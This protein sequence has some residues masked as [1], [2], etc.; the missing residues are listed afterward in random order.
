MG[1][2]AGL[3]FETK[4]FAKYD[5]AR[6]LEDALRK[7]GYQVA[8]IAL[9]TNTDPYQPI[10]RELKLTSSILAVL[11]DC[12]HPVTIVTKSAGILRDLDRLSRMARRGLVSVGLSVTTLDAALSRLMEPALFLAST[13]GSIPSATWLTPGFRCGSWLSPMIPGLNDCELEAIL[14]AAR[15]AGARAASMIPLRLPL[16]VKDVF[17]DWLEANFP[18]RAKKVMSQVTSMHGGKVYRANFG[19][20]MRGS[21]P[22]AHILRHRFQVACGRTGLSEHLRPLVRGRVLP[23]RA[24]RGPVIAALSA[25]TRTHCRLSGRKSGQCCLWSPIVLG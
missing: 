14:E 7:P 20:R 23:A 5:V 17:R 4:L 25:T 24:R 8:P 11:D 19:E 15:K 13:A 18:D 16:E 3:D 9:G 21:G 1:L 22:L 10:E 2:S 6:L 12:N